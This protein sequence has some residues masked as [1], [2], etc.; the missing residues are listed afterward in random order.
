MV[1]GK[2]FQKSALYTIVST[3]YCNLYSFSFIDLVDIFTHYL[4][5]VSIVFYSQPFPQYQEQTRKR[6]QL[7][8]Q[9]LLFNILHLGRYCE[10]VGN[11]SAPFQKVRAM[12]CKYYYYGSICLTYF[13]TYYLFFFFLCL[14]LFPAHT[15]KKQH[16]IGTI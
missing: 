1:R 5:F 14:N 16:S 7:H 9:V 6:Y 2:L 4:L 13:Y 10:I 12:C 3:L 8:C 11:S 15:Q